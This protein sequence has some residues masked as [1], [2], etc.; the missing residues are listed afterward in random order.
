MAQN[1]TAP[2][3]ARGPSRKADRPLFALLCG[4]ALGSAPGASV[5]AAD[6]APAAAPESFDSYVEASFVALADRPALPLAVCDTAICVHYEA[7]SDEPAAALLLASARD[8]YDALL[9]LKLPRPLSDGGRGGDGR[10]DVYLDPARAR[11]DTWIDPGAASSGWDRATAFITSPALGSGCV[12]Q[13][14]LAE[15]LAKVLLASQDGALEPNAASMLS[16][17][18]AQVTKPCAITLSQ[19]VDFAQRAPERTFTGRRGQPGP[20]SLLFPWFLEESFG[21]GEIGTLTMSLAAISSQRTT[22]GPLLDE[23]DMFDSLRITQ[24]RNQTSL[25]QTLLDHAVARAFLGSR[26]DGLHLTDVEQLGEFG[27]PRME[28]SVTHKSLPRRLAPLRPIESLGATYLFVDLKGAAAGSELTFVADWE[29]PVAFR[30]ALVKLD[31]DGIELGRVD[32][33]PVLGETHIEKTV[34]ELGDA[35]SLLIVGVNEGEGRRD[36]P[37]DTARPHEEPHAYLVTLY[38]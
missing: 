8:S 24:L 27:R 35:E 30:W 26:C 13:N 11:P 23:P 10:V 14:E 32:A 33:V 15:A 16:G 34:R 1:P 36:E 6:G 20:A 19:A 5:E 29:E 22:K 21:S 31:K 2:W 7:A 37:F 25:A 38:P 12:R 17:Y 18:L 4:L 3:L 9:A 28:W